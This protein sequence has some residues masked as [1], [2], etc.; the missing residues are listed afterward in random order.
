MAD[1][2]KP[3]QVW[4]MQCDEWRCVFSS[5][6]PIEATDYAK[7]RISYTGKSVQRVELR[8]LTGPLDTIY[9]SSWSHDA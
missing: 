1:K 6:N 7:T 8:D 4:V 2:P 5:H 3:Y 9:D